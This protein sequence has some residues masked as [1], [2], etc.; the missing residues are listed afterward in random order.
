M[1]TKVN[2]LVSMMDDF[3]HKV[4]VEKSA[5]YGGPDDEAKKLAEGKTSKTISSAVSAQGTFGKEKQKDMFVGG[6]QA[7][8][9]AATNK[10]GSAVAPGAGQWPNSLDADESVNEGENMIKVDEVH[11]IARA[12]Y[13]GNQILGRVSQLRKQ[14]SQYEDNDG[15]FITKLAAQSPEMAQHVALSFDSY[16]RG[17][18]RGMQKKAEDMVETLDSGVVENPEEAEAILNDIAAQ[19]PEAVMPE[20]A[21]AE[22]GA[23]DG[24]LS[25]DEEGQLEELAAALAESGV[26]PEQVVEAAQQVEELQAAGFSPDEIAAAAGEVMQEGPAME[27][28]MAYNRRNQLKNYI[29]SLSNA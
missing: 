17:F 16:A 13:L 14:A 26:T 24:S 10:D 11:K 22:A 27:Q 20:E 7:D 25:P 4:A 21:M 6:T 1:S 23:V 28:K 19:N 18:V 9:E 15:L 12:E 2:D 8:S 3:L 29:K 5:G